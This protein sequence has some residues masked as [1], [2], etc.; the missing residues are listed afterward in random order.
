[1]EKGC[2][3]NKGVDV[4]SEELTTIVNSI[5]EKGLFPDELKIADVSPL[6]FNND[7]NLRRTIGQSVFYVI[8]QR[9]SRDSSIRR[10]I[11]SCHHIFFLIF[12]L[13]ERITTG[14]TCS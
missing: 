9:F 2:I 10:S 1:M 7:E 13:S 14:N 11:T 3:G 5:L 8:G 4:Y 6:I 12:V